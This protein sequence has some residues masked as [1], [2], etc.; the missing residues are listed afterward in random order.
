MRIIKA[1]W[2]PHVN[3]LK[4]QCDCGRVFRHWTRFILMTCPSCQRQ[5]T[6]HE[7]PNSGLPQARVDLRSAA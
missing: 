3:L 4:V 6:W 7:W 2:T 1:I 5:N